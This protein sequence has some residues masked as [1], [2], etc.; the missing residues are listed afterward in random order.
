MSSQLDI[1]SQIPADATQPASLRNKSTNPVSKSIANSVHRYD[2][3]NQ[4]FI[5][6]FIVSP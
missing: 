1:L 6:S 2:L 4:V 5:A 3:T